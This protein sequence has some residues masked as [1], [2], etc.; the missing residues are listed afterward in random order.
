MIQFLC[1]YALDYQLDFISLID[2]DLSQRN[3]MGF[4]GDNVFRPSDLY[5]EPSN[6]AAY[7][8][9]YVAILIFMKIDIGRS[10]YLYPISMMLTLSTAGFIMGVVSFFA[11]FVYKSKHS[12]A[13]SKALVFPIIILCV[14]LFSIPQ[15]SRFSDS[16]IVANV[17]TNLRLKLVGAVIDSALSSPVKTMIGTGIYSYSKSIYELENTSS[18]R[19]IAS[20]QDSS[21]I[22]YFFMSFGIVGLFFIVWIIGTPSG[23]AQKLSV[24]SVL[25]SKMSFLFPIFIFLVVAVVLSKLINCRVAR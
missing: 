6:Y 12:G 11:M 4:G 15:L 25:L 13:L 10:K 20:V 9:V 5:F 1:Y 7:M 23:L 17:N 22:V 19:A 24:F 14:F 18:G 8:S 16:S 2:S 3:W 21:M